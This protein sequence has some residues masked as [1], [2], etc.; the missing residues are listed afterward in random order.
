MVVGHLSMAVACQTACSD[1]KHAA[2]FEKEAPDNARMG[3]GF[4]GTKSF[5]LCSSELHREDM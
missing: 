3:S 2:P 5:Q 1:M 4:P